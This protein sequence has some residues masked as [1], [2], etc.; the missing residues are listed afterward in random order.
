M[1][2]GLH[3]RLS[4]RL[5]FVSVLRALNRIREFIEIRNIMSRS[6][7][8]IH[9]CFY[10]PT[11]R[12]FYCHQL[13]KRNITV[14]QSEWYEWA[15][16]TDLYFFPWPSLCSYTRYIVI[17]RPNCCPNPFKV[18]QLAKFG[19]QVIKKW[20]VNPCIQY[21]DSEKPG[22]IINLFINFPFRRNSSFSQQLLRLVNGYFCLQISMIEVLDSL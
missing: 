20:T 22:L 11:A 18:F 16:I 3:F 15:N 7:N 14:A 1:S 17:L 4:H 5:Q 6:P 9:Y 8:L 12:M 2:S 21:T 10:N 19:N 13:L